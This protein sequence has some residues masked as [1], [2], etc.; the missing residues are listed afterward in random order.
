MT[1]TLLICSVLSVLTAAGGCGEDRPGSAPQAPKISAG[2]K[3]YVD[4]VTG[5]TLERPHE[6]AP[7]LELDDTHA[8]SARGLHEIVS[9]EPGGGV[10]VDLEGRFQV[11]LEATVTPDGRPS[12]RHRDAPAA[13]RTAP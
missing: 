6:M 12:I 8:T 10:S 13:P 1:R 3:A 11:P 5:E 7:A 2:F 9:P 4:P